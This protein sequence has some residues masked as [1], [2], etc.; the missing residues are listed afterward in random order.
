MR[1]EAVSALAAAAP[2]LLGTSH[3]QAPVKALVRRIREGLTHYFQ[4]PDGYEVVLGNGGATLVWD[5][6][7]HGVIARRSAHAVFGEF[8]AKFAAAVRRAPFLDDPVIVESP[9]GTHPELPV[10]AGVDAYALTHCETSTGVAMPVVR[11]APDGLVLVDATSAAGSLPVDP[12]QFDVYYCSPQKG[13]ASEGGLFLALLS[14]SAVARLDQSTATSPPRWTCAS[15]WRTAGWTRPT[16]PPRSPRCTSWPTASTGS[17]PRAAW[18]RSPSRSPRSPTRSTPG[19]RTAPSL[20][21]SCRT[22]PS[23]ARSW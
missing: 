13:F 2:T 6:L 16:T 8:S 7:V 15:R 1:P 18:T 21:R 4:L 14:P 3:R 10:I 17:T 9:P 23:A 19:P 12:Q 20:L 5:A 22:R 11:P